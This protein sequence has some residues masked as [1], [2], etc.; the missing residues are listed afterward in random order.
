MNARSRLL[1]NIEVPGDSFLDTGLLSRGIDNYH[2]DVRLSDDFVLYSR[3]IIEKIA[4]RVAA[5]KRPPGGSEEMDEFRTSYRKMMTASLHRTKS[6]WT[7]DQLKVLHFGVIKFLLKEVRRALSKLNDETEAAVAQQQFAGSRSLLATQERLAWLR[8][9]HDDFLFQANRAIFQQVQREENGLRELRK[10]ITPDDNGNILNVMFN[11]MLCADSPIDIGMVAE[12]YAL[13][14]NGGKGFAA[15]NL[16]L[17]DTL[18]VAVPELQTRALKEDAKIETT[19]VFDTLHGLFSSQDILGPSEDQS[20]TLTESY[21]WLEHPGNVRALL[22]PFVQE[23]ELRELK[24][25]LGIKGQWELKG[26]LKKLKKLTNDLRNKMYTDIEFREAVA[27]YLL[28]GS[29]SASDQLLLDIRLACAYVAGNDSKKAL[30]RLDQSREGAVGLVKRLDDLMDQISKVIKEEGEEYFLRILS[31]LFRYR[32]HLKYF[33]FAHRA[34]NRINVITDAKEIQLA[35]AGG[36]LYELI[37]EDELKEFSTIESEIVRHVIL[38]ADVRGST[39]VTRE[40]LK[41]SLNPASYFSLRF[42]GPI[43]ER[44]QIYGA[45]KVFIEGDAVILGF[46][47]HNDAPNHWYAV[48]RACGMAKEIIDIVISKNAHAAKTG[49]PGLEVGIGI[50]FSADKPLFLFDEDKPIMISSAIGDAD[51]F[52]SC[53]WR[54][55][56][57]YQGRFNVDLLESDQQHS[58]K[59]QDHLHYNLNGISLSTPGFKKLMSEIPLKKLKLKTGESSET[60]FV[61]KF[62]DLQ[63]KERDLVIR[64]GRVGLWKDGKVQRDRREEVFYE[65]LRNSKLTRQ[66][67]DLSK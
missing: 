67:I 25:S 61:G 57:G 27:C 26:E 62:P 4:K 15:I 43:N 56:D 40:L 10:Q 2:I 28:R 59:G 35:R 53:S 17:E 6:D 8:K 20:T 11:P 33:R 1:A 46:Y 13:W 14:P 3:E 36:Q 38:K 60:V 9:H 51:R 44:L 21:G 39:T 22:D 48:S 55:R 30:G 52:S 16:R 5:G 66:V 63:G 45:A 65:V 24:D 49:L 64:E 54:L 31:D 23:K 37:D 58:E 29:W 19:E 50:C 18:N 47:E 41:Q 12:C 7:A 32:L 42:F 34:L